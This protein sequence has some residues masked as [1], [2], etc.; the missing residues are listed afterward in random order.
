MS[1]DQVLAYDRQTEDFVLGF[2]AGRIWALARS[3]LAYFDEVVHAANAENI[4]RIAEATHRV[5][6]SEEIDD[7][8][9]HVFFE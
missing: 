2:E 3:D 8:W 9:I 4:L 7:L 6:R 5:V 1:Y